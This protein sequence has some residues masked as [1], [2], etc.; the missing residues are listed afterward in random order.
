[1]WSAQLIAPASTHSGGCGV[2]IR[3]GA[4]L[5]G[6]AAGGC[7]SRQARAG[8]RLELADLQP[9]LLNE[10]REVELLV[11]AHLRRQALSGTLA[12]RPA[13]PEARKQTMQL[14]GCSMRRQA[15]P[16]C[17]P[18]SAVCASAYD[19]TRWRHAL[20]SSHSRHVA[21]IGTLRVRPNGRPI[22]ATLWR[23]SPACGVHARARACVWVRVCVSV[24]AC[25]CVRACVRVCVCVCV[26]SVCV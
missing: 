8:E 24:C 19:A 6:T 21:R 3:T 13:C 15:A 12:R 23:S 10:Q 1:M 14:E 26:C 16:R 17:C 20:D 2:V 7:A 25:A 11:D 9:Q 18:P 5:W 4:S 22:S